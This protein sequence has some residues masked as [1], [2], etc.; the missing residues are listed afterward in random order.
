MTYFIDCC[1]LDLLV[2]YL[3]PFQT[4]GLACTTCSM[5]SSRWNLSSHASLPGY[6]LEHPF[7]SGQ[8][9]YVAKG[10]YINGPRFPPPPVGSCCCLDN[11]ADIM[12]ITCTSRPI[13]LP[14]RFLCC[15]DTIW[16]ARFM[17]G[18]RQRKT[19]KQTLSCASQCSAPCGT[20]LQVWAALCVQVVQNWSCLRGH[21]LCKGSQGSR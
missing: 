13:I 6:E 15:L 7:A 17:C 3:Q 11:H 12:I 14:S 10:A 16:C 2:P 19:T 4:V 8:F 5:S 20:A 21:V 1:T 18:K 9:R